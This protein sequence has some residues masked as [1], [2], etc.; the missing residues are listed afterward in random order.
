MWQGW[1]GTLLIH[2]TAVIHLKLLM[3]RESYAVHIRPQKPTTTTTFPCYLFTTRLTLSEN[4]TE[5]CDTGTSLKTISVEFPELDFSNVDPTFPDKSPNTPYA[6]T[7]S[8]NAARG[9]SCLSRLYNRSEK[10]IAVVSHSGFLRTAISKRRY[11]NADYRV[12][13]FRK[14]KS[15][16]LSLLEDSST[17]KRGGGMGRSVKGLQ[18]IEDWDFPPENLALAAE[19]RFPQSSQA[20][21]GV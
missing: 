4:S 1:L 14:A 11:A 18:R 7:R 6:F 5:P 8:A 10:V 17:A 9:Q 19:D 16:R 3:Q 15:G 21:N 2:T 20:V 12:F 13:S